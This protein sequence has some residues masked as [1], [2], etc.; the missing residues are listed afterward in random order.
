MESVDFFDGSMVKFDVTHADLN[1][2]IF[3]VFLL[4]VVWI[5]QEKYTY[6]RV[7]I[8]RQ[9]LP[10]RWIVWLGLAVLILVYGNYGPG[11]DAADFIY[12]GF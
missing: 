3:G 6:A 12:R 1:I 4:F 10:F 2:I 9:I 5:L 11:Y 8:Q 7:W